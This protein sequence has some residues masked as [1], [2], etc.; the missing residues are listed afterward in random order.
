M[1]EER[2]GFRVPDESDRLTGNSPG[3][4]RLSL[5]S[6][7]NPGPP[8]LGTTTDS[9]SSHYYW[10]SLSLHPRSASLFPL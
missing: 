2:P 5:Q 9:P 6:T 7:A 1:G 10:H 8:K 3:S 4:P